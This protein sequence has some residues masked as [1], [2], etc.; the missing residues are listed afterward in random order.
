MQPLGIAPEVRPYT[1]HLTLASIARETPLD[2]LLNAIEDLPSR[3]FGVLAPGYFSLFQSGVID[4]EPVYRKVADFPL[5]KKAGGRP[6][7]SKPGR[8]LRLV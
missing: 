1:P 8:S 7:Y 5:F 6:L 3:E 4:N 2:D